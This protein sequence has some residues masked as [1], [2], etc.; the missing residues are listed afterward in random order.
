MDTDLWHDQR[1]SLVPLCRFSP[2]LKSLHLTS[3]SLPDSKIF[4]FVCSFPILEDL[5]LASRNRRQ[6]DM[7]WEPPSTSPR[8]T[9]ALEL[10]LIEGIQS[11]ADKL[12]DHPNGLHFTKITVS[13]VSEGDNLSTMDL[14]SRCS[15]T[16]ESLDI[17][18]FF[19]GAISLSSCS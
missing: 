3:T 2:V 9:G 13:W 11:T 1:V 5:T 12:L 4:H 19:S 17:S 14:V 8:L 6:S 15:G 16:L 10:R 18:D 7:G